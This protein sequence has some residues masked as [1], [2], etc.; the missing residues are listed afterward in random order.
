MATQVGTFV[1]MK[2]GTL[3]LVGESTTSFKSAQAMIE[4]S[5]KTSGSNAAFVGG[6]LTQTMNVSSIASTNPAA[7]GYGF[8]A[9]LAAQAAGTPIAVTITEYS[10]ATGTT[11]VTGATKL[12]ANVLFADVALEAPDNAK[13]TFSLSMQITG[14]TTVT[15]N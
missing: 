3:L 11:A 7:A 8:A 10:D 6:R 1:M 12:A 13:L 15:T 9:A 5:N 2:I 4:I 14:G